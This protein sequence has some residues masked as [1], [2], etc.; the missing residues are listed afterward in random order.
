[1]QNVIHF[2]SYLK[3]L[4]PKRNVVHAFFGISATTKWIFTQQRLKLYLGN[5]MCGKLKL[6]NILNF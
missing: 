1:M 6:E 2:N 4:N 3:S 5:S